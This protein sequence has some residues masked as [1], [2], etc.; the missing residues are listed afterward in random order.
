MVRRVIILFYILNGT[1]ATANAQVNCDSLIGTWT[2]TGMGTDLVYFDSEDSAATIDSKIKQLNKDGITLKKVDTLELID[3]WRKLMDEFRKEKIMTFRLNN[4]KSF[5]WV[6][7]FNEPELE[8]SG[9][10]TCKGDT[11]IFSS[12]G[13][14]KEGFDGDLVF[15]IKSYKNSRLRLH[16]QSFGDSRRGPMKINELMFKRTN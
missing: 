14:A 7:T 9:T 13:E 6:G 3:G 16:V 1:L 5:S 15:I 8:F 12:T 4:D 2:F 11:L 10:Y